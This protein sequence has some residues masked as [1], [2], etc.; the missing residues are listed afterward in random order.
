MLH[1]KLADCE[2]SELLALGQPQE[3]QRQL[4]EMF[5]TNYLIGIINKGSLCNY[6]LKL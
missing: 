4:L 3:T 2:M 1:F 6:V 5:L